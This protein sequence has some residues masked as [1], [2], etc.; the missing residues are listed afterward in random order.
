MKRTIGGFTLVELLV[1][2]T[3]IAMLASFATP[4]ITSAIERG[5]S[6][7]CVG[8]LR[9]IG[10]AVQQYIADNDNTFPSIAIPGGSPIEG[11]EGKPPLEL[12][13]P[14]GL[15][16]STLTCPTD[17]ALGQPPSI[18]EYGSSYIFSPVVDGENSINPKIYTRRGI[19]SVSNVGRLTVASDFTGIHP[20]RAGEQ[21]TPFIK[22][23][24]NVLKADGRV[25][26]R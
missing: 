25:I 7:K 19:F 6:A 21:E 1:V 24:M 17:A 8:N 13:G 11:H 16:A 18:E 5:R 10:V 3:I 2:I 26:Q 14:Y 4:V 12:L 20:R 22:N 9:Q 23:G 15:T